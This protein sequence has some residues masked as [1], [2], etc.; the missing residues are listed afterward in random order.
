[1][2]ILLVLLAVVAFNLLGTCSSTC[3]S[4]SLL[5]CFAQKVAADQLMLS[6]VK[7]YSPVQF[8]SFLCSIIFLFTPNAEPTQRLMSQVDINHIELFSVFPQ[9]LQI[10]V[11]FFQFKH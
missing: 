3:M 8:T 7:T 1:M 2:Y 11:L 6:F 9:S 5:Y 4:L 10:A